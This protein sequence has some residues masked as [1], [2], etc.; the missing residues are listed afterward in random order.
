[1]YFYNLVLVFIIVL[2]FLISIGM[3]FQIIVP[4]FSVLILPYYFQCVYDEC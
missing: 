4:W 2:R 3:E 1:M